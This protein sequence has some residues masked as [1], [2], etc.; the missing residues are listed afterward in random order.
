MYFLKQRGYITFVQIAS[1]DFLLLSLGG[2]A[3]IEPSLGLGLPD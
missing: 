2:G 3:A 1:V